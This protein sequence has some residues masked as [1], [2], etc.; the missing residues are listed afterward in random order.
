MSNRL[1]ITAFVALVV[2][3]VLVGGA[4]LVHARSEDP[5]HGKSTEPVIVPDPTNFAALMAAPHVIFRN[6]DL[7]RHY[8][9]VEVVPLSAPTG[10]RS[11]TPI[12]CDRVAMEGDVG[13]CLTTKQGV[14][15]TYAG[16]IFDKNFTVVHKFALPGLPSRLRVSPDA[17]FA[18]F[19]TFVHGD[20]YASTGF[21]TR[22]LF[23]DTTTG[24]LIANLESFKVTDNGNPV[25]AA[26]RNFW[27]VTFAADSNK[28]YATLAVGGDTHLIEGDLQKREAH[29]IYDNVECPSLSPDQMHIAYKKRV[30]NG[31]GPV[32]WRLHVL[33][34]RTMTDVALAE[35]RSIDD[36]VEWLD[37]KT[38]L[39]SVPRAHTGTVAWDTYAV[40]ADGSGAAQIYVRGSSSPG[41]EQES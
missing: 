41:V 29:T 1:R 21:S 10:A 23:I 6:T 16:E 33:D 25:T 37:A 12:T 8:G 31:V 28:F 22:T 7:G 32:K 38:V 18:S 19:T 13:V 34:L 15:T 30:P 26:S 40:P 39:Y 9:K 20:S 36:Q 14:V 17:R 2:V 27:G 4:Y 5:R 3:C 11:V 24:R 35:T